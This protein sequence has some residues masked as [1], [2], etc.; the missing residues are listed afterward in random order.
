MA[1]SIDSYLRTLS[2]NY[3]LKRDAS[4]TNKISRSV[5][6]LLSNLDTELGWR[7]NRRFIFG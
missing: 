5:A 2:Y 7:I 4:E 6:H 3:Y 1:V